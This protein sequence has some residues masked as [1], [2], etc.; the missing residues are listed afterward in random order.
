M[1]NVGD[2][3]G[4][5][6][7]EKILLYARGPEDLRQAWNEIPPDA[8]LFRPTPDSWSAWEIVCHCADSEI[9]AATRI[10]MLVAEADP[11]IIGYDQ[12]AWT[13]IFS[14][15]ELD[16]DLAFTVIT[17]ARAWTV[18][19]LEQLT[20]AQWESRGM[21]SESGHYSAQNWLDNYSVHLL[22]HAEQIRSNQR[23]WHARNN[24]ES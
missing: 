17:A 12:D 14:Y 10:R 18:P 20:D 16:A 7:R 1:D 6:R 19:V 24:P 11:A 5:Q 8:R 2:P 9:S 4:V 13:K 15:H 22:D 21:H 23:A 3:D